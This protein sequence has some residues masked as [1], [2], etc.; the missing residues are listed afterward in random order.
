MA[1]A[2]LVAAPVHLKLRCRAL[3]DQPTAWD[4][5]RPA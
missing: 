1:M 3:P 5:A 4:F 2:A